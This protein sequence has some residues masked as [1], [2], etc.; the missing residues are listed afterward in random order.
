MS[1][2]PLD[3]TTPLNETRQTS[4][5]TSSHMFQ[6]SFYS[7]YFDINTEDFFVKIRQ[8]LNP[9]DHS[10]ALHTDEDQAT[11][12]YGFLWINA[13]LVFLMFVSSTGSNLLALWLHSDDTDAPY[14]YNF[15]LL[16]SSIFYFYG[17]SVLAPLAFWGFSTYVA[18]FDKPLSLTRLISVYSYSSVFW[19][20]TTVANI[21]LAVFIS[22][23]T[24]KLLLVIL[25]LILVGLS[26]IFSGLSIAWKV[27]PIVQDNMARDNE[28]DAKKTKAMILTLMALHTGFSVLIYVIFFSS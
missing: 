28:E 22:K 15:K 9:F 11:E 10:S 5:S 6:I 2:A 3:P 16:T 19:I 14:E 13:T 8:A 4:K 20:P 7:Q 26:G 27:R 23:K 12:L 17:Y 24:H 25:Q 18:K 21:I 1:Q